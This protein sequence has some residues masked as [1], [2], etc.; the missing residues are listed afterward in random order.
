MTRRQAALLIAV[1]AIFVAC[2]GFGFYDFPSGFARAYFVIALSCFIF[3][4]ITDGSGQAV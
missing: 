3:W 4:L 2:C 1:A